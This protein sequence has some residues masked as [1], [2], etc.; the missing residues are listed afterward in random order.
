MEQNSP[1]RQGL[2]YSYKLYF[3]HQSS[4]PLFHSKIVLLAT[5]GGQKLCLLSLAWIPHSWK[6]LGL[7]QQETSLLEASAAF[8]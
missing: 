8:M 2:V 3:F 7:A 4:N 1:E 5:G 6:T